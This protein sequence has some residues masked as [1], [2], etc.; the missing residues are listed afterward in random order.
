MK[1]IIFVLVVLIAFNVQAQ[2]EHSR[3]ASNLTP[4]QMATMRTKQI[5]LA[6]DLSEAQ[7]N[8]VLTLNKKNAENFSKSK[9]ERKEL[10]SDER[11]EMKNKMMDVQIANQRA[12]K[13]ILNED[14][15]GRWKKMQ[16]SRMQKMNKAR[17]S[18]MRKQ[19]AQKRGVHRSRSG[20]HKKTGN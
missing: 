6:L 11:F 13:D 4:E 20:E 16:K 3:K 8:D 14:Q 19:A 9:G 18:K 12:M 5:T 10:T 2:R 7:Q 15:Y 17:S 1:K